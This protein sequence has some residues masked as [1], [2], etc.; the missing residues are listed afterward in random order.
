LLSGEAINTNF[1]VFGL[2]QA[3]DLPL[4]ITPL[5]R[6]VLIDLFVEIVEPKLLYSCDIGDSVILS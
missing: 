2:A 4:T 1:I 5:R 3:H 6:L